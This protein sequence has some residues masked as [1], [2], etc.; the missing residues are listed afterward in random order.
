MATDDVLATGLAVSPAGSA[1][2][3]LGVEVETGKKSLST[4]ETYAAING[5]FADEL[6]VHDFLQF[7]L[8]EVEDFETGGLDRLRADFGFLGDE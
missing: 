5:V 3:N 6:L 4:V 7:G 2:V 1:G 8:D